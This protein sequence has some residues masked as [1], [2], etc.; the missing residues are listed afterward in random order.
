MACVKGDE[1]VFLELGA[2]DAARRLL[3]KSVRRVER[4]AAFESGLCE[5]EV[6]TGNAAYKT[7]EHFYLT[8]AQ[9]DQAY[10]R[11]A[12]TMLNSSVAAQNSS[13]TNSMTNM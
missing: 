6:V 9:A 11:R 8:R 5:F 3:P 2:L 12:F 4:E 1:I 13:M 10:G 7:G